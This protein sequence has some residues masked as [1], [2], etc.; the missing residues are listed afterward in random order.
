LKIFNMKSTG[1]KIKLG[2][3]VTIGL[4]IFI[5]AIY[6]IG[7]QQK[8]F[9]TTFTLQSVFYD[10]SGLQVGNNVRFSGIRVGVVNDIRIISDSLVRVEMLI[11][12]DVR[13]FIRKD[14][15][16]VIGSEGLMG[17]KVINILAG[18]P[19]SEIIAN[20]DIIQSERAIDHLLHSVQHTIE[21][22]EYIS[23]DLAQITH[24]VAQGRG[25]AGAILMDTAIARNLESTM[26]NIQRGTRGFE[27]NMEALQDNFLLRGYFR[28]Q[29]RQTEREQKR[30]EREQAREQRKQEKAAEKEEGEPQAKRG[31]FGRRKNGNN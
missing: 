18:N 19:T 20:N 29:E 22:I 5:L 9:G 13:Q 28:R 24:S 15:K 2:F 21:N 8:L 3:F 25:L 27:E 7:R 17:N 16:A 12:S 30:Q 26:K 31:L 10:V 1:A 23:D 6:T 14:S 4:A 11:D